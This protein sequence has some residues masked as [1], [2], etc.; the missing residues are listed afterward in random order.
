MINISNYL[1]HVLKNT[2]YLSLVI[3]KIYRILSYSR[4]QY[5][6]FDPSKQLNSENFNGGLNDLVYMDN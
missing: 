5:K 6:D 2:K 1:F 3:Y 4:T